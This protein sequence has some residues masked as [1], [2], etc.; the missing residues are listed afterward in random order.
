MFKTVN[1][2]LTWKPYTARCSPCQFEQVT[3]SSWRNYLQRNERPGGDGSLSKLH[4]LS[5]VI[6]NL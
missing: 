3:T 1:K 2:S 5:S 4:W 6:D